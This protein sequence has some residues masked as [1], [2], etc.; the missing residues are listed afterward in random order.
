[1]ALERN[2]SAVEKLMLAAMRGIGPTE[3]E[4]TT[5]QMVT[6]IKEIFQMDSGTEKGIFEKEKQG[7]SI[8]VNT[9][10]IR[11]VALER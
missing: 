2:A 4:N 1:M 3:T 6:F 8:E 7:S 5:G 11:S 10:M 9:T